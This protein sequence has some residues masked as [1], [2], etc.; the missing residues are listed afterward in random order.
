M[1]IFK[2]IDLYNSYFLIL[3]SFILLYIY[4]INTN[5]YFFNDDFVLIS[6][7]INNVSLLKPISSHFRPMV[8]IHF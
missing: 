7:A 4:L 3:F 8:R 6:D 1:K 2:R 5:N